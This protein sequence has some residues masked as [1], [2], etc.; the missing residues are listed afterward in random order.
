MP[1]SSVRPVDR[2]ISLSHTV[3]DVYLRT[4]GT[5]ILLRSQPAV[6]CVSE[7]PLVPVS[8]RRGS[9]WATGAVAWR[10]RSPRTRSGR[11]GARTPHRC[12]RRRRSG[13]VDRRSTSGPR[14]LRPSQPRRGRRCVGGSWRQSVG[15]DR[16]HS[17]H[18][19]QVLGE[20]SAGAAR[21]P[22]PGSGRRLTFVPHVSRHRP[23]QS[24]Q[25]GLAQDLNEV[26]ARA[27]PLLLAS[28]DRVNFRDGHRRCATCN[29]SRHPLGAADGL[30]RFELILNRR[31]IAHG[32][33]CVRLRRAPGE[34]GSLPHPMQNRGRSSTLTVL[35]LVSPLA[36]MAFH[37]GQRSRR[38]PIWP[39][40]EQ[41]LP[42]R[43]E[44]SSPD[45]PIHPGD[46]PDPLGVN[47]RVR[48]PPALWCARS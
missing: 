9:A 31:D 12:R 47:R 5:V 22:G 38:L 11:P 13:S 48:F 10:R 33:I 36:V 28:V 14:K 42:T 45:D 32:C 24:R 40:A 30:Q 16:A 20:T 27:Q 39:S 15:P 29:S 8:S 21:R 25:A 23:L 34:G 4:I 17:E 2:R 7:W 35:H 43:D 3:S 18:A 1:G 6:G 44:W 19:G 26:T 46:R 41:P 37:G